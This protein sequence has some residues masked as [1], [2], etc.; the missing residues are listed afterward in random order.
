MGLFS[1][2]ITLEKY[3]SNFILR[4][5]MGFTI[6]WLKYHWKQY[7]KYFRPIMNGIVNFLRCDDN[8]VVVYTVLILGRCMHKC[9][10][11]KCYEVFNHPSKWYG[12]RKRRCGRTRYAKMLKIVESPWEYMS[13]YD[14]LSVGLTI[15]KIKIWGNMY[16]HI[17]S[18]V[19]KYKYVERPS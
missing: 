1:L 19:Y 7:L 6:V 13:V 10:G 17:I 5:P 12:K 18:T 15:F 3:F 2:S 9:L 8:V 11:D 14:I 16:I 4:N